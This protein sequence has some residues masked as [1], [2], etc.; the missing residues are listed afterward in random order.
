MSLAS[1]NQISA[2][3]LCVYKI[4]QKN[5]FFSYCP[6]CGYPTLALKFFISLTIIYAILFNSYRLNRTSTQV[7]SWSFYQA[8]Y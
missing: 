6:K 7:D 8:I 2:G 1:L 4:F 5:V 3:G